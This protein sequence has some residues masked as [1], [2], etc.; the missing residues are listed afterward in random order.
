[1]LSTQGLTVT[2][3]TQ[4]GQI[5][6]VRGVDLTLGRGEKLGLAGESGSGKSTLALALLRLLP[7]NA[8]VGG[9]VLLGG[10]DVLAMRWGRLRA[11]R[12][13]VASIVFQGA[14]HSLNPVQRIGGQI[15]EPILR[16][17]RVDRATADRR[18]RELLDQVGMPSGRAGAY[19]HELSGGQRQRV[20]IAM[21]LACEPDLIIADEPTTALDV[22]VQA[23]I[24][25]L[26]D[27]LV[28][29]R[30]ISLLMISHDLSVLAHGCDRLAIL[31]AGRVVEVGPA[32]EV[33]Q[34]A[35]HPYAMAL[36]AAYQTVGEPAS[37][38]RPRGLAG[39]PP[40][41]QELPSGCAFH[42]RCAARLDGC[43]SLDPR[44]FPAG[45]AHAAACVRVLPDYGKALAG[46]RPPGGGGPVSTGAA[47]RG[48]SLRADRDAPLLR[49]RD[50]QVEFPGRRG[51]RPA[52]AV[53]GVDLDLWAGEIVALVGESG[54]GKTTLARTLLG[55]QRTTSGTVAYRGAPLGYRSRD[56]KAFRREAQL[57]LQDP[58]G[59]L[60]PRH[61]VYDAVAE[62][63]R[64][65]GEVAD[66]QQQV[67]DALSRA[68]LK[69][70]ERYFLRYPHELSGGQCQR[71]VIAG[72]LVLEPAL[73]VADEPV[74]SLDTSVRGE[75]LSLLLRLRD[76]LGL[77]ALVVTHDLG[78]AWNIADRV[79]VMYLGR[80]VE[81]GPAEKVLTAP[82]HPYTQALLSVLPN[83]GRP[84]ALHGDPPDPTR[85]PAG[86][87]F[88][89]RCQVL[90]SGA[91]DGAGV[92]DACRDADLP[93]LDGGTASQVACHV[94]HTLARSRRRPD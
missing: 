61:T 40:D 69:P 46:G 19:P 47:P 43:V 80:V 91:A 3:R 27:D 88:H 35:R 66:E 8:T 55:L 21:A 74:A 10:E 4:G 34:R 65:H 92:A 86:C 12:W 87:R 33:F 23:Q 90:A 24:L 36:A 83:G 7:A 49:A 17:Q 28:A 25:R 77:A 93:V 67:A 26:V 14:M 89:V 81:T 79:A 70:P 82:E 42:P 2:Y 52:R 11:V 78:L 63:L 58:G 22:M 30:G 31:Y 75:I 5:P 60:N 48:P 53:D 56:L 45:L 76:D 50:L 85:I 68:G 37:R 84:V 57:V 13:A 15:A 62:G 72:A 32:A 41:P 9:R 51:A 16:H 20:M 39:D 6:A 44:L 59:S 54:W 38:L 64:I 18:V 73:L 1:M 29:S 71:V 94:A